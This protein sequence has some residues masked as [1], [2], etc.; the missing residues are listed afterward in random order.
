MV[1]VYFVLLL[2]SLSGAKEH[3]QLTQANILSGD[4]MALIANMELA[5]KSRISIQKVAKAYLYLGNNIA[6][7]KATK[8]LKTSLNVF[9]ENMR[10]LE[11]SINDPREKNLL[12]YMQSSREEVE[13][14]IK[15]PYSL[16]NAAYV[17]ELSEALSEGGLSIM[18]MFKK[19]MIGNIP[20][21]KGGRY[22]AAQI[23]KYYMAYKAGIKDDNTVKQMK[24]TVSN[25]EKVLTNLRDYQD[26]TVEMNKLMHKM[27]K[28]WKI[29]NKFYLDIEQGG[30]PLIVYQTT[31]KIETGIGR[32]VELLLKLKTKKQ[33][34]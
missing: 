22:Y 30:L 9:N 3:K 13:E 21:F 23:A 31:S 34:L 20:V 8:E 5:M 27:D 28:L 17:M 18:E 12:L 25:L 29:V 24:K 10:L 26:N 6:T 4:D 2:S 11:E 19:K 14:L 7:S 15:E 32:Y 33:R 1:S 16:D